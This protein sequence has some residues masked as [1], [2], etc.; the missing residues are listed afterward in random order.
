MSAFAVVVLAVA[1]NSWSGQDREKQ[2]DHLGVGLAAHWTFDEGEGS[3]A[4]SLIGAVTPA[5]L[6][7]GP[8]WT[9]GKIGQGLEFDGSDDE[10]ALPPI[11]LGDGTIAAWVKWNTKS[12]LLAGGELIEGYWFYFDE[13]AGGVRINWGGKHKSFKDVFD[14]GVWTHVATTRDDSL[15]R[16]YKDGILQQTLTGSMDTTTVRGIGALYAASGLFQRF[17]GVIDDVRIYD[18]ALSPGE[19]HLVYNLKSAPATPRNPLSNASFAA[20][21]DS[22]DLSSGLVSEWSFDEGRGAPARNAGLT[23][24][25]ATAQDGPTL[26]SGTIG[27]ALQFDGQDDEL[28]L[29]PIQV[30]DGTIAAWVL[31][32]TKSVLLAGNDYDE[33]YWFLFDDEKA[34]VNINWGGKH[35]AF[36]DIFEAGVW[37]H[38]ATSRKD[39]LISLYK[40][41]VL[42]EK[43]NSGSTAAATIRSVGALYATNGQF[44]RLDGV[45]DELR[46][47]D[48]A[49][50]PDEIQVLYHMNRP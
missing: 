42:R 10:L 25:A 4:H 46:V 14:V 22:F 43:I 6:L 9:T 36:A 32:N 39:S 37:T 33:G 45:L 50:T 3:R 2:P 23:D 5:V 49:L 11:K 30:G 34:R 20:Y 16:L 7:N 38:V 29:S 48:R 35:L 26:T 17:D 1:V 8:V 24:E 21:A 28:V 15:I 18:R 47:Y 27:R 40:D 12:V 31:W 19:I 41:G 44:Q 13:E